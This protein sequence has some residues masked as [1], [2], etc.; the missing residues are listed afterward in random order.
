VETKFPTKFL[1]EMEEHW[2]DCK[3][4]FLIFEKTSSSGHGTKD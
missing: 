1:V 4:N 3:A 2:V